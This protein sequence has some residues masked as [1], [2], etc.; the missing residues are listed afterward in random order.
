MKRRISLNSMLLLAAI[1]VAALAAEPKA[2][3]GN[4]MT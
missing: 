1:P 3:A 2:P 4:P